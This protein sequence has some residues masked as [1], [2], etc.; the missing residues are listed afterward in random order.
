MKKLLS[1]QEAAF[2]MGVSKETLRNWE[3]KGILVSYRTVG[4]HRRY[5]FEDLEKLKTNKNIHESGQRSTEK[6]VHQ[7]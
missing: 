2:E 4:N 5:A 3:R 1:I 7:T 6:Q